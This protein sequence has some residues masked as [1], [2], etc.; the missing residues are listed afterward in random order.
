MQFIRKIRMGAQVAGDAA[1]RAGVSA[2][3][4][5]SSSRLDELD[6]IAVNLQ[7]SL[8]Y[9]HYTFGFSWFGWTKRAFVDSDS[10][11]A[12]LNS[13]QNASEVRYVGA[14]FV[15]AYPQNSDFA[16]T[17]RLSLRSSIQSRLSASDQSKING[18][19]MGAL[20]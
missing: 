7:Y 17:D 6:G 11:I 18:V 5:I 15:K 10:A 20:I 3:T 4:G 9:W 1:S 16:P 14:T 12:A 13:L 8:W 19:V 2:Q